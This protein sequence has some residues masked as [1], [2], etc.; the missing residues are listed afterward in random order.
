MGAQNILTLTDDNF[1]DRLTGAAY[2]VLVDFWAAWCGPCKVIA[3][4][5]EELADELSG[6]ALI[7]KID[8]EDNGGLANRFGISSIP[9]LILFKNGRVVDQMIGAV[10][11][12]QIRK[13]VEK[14]LS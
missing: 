8:V 11:K 1:D 5:L 14:H 7:G 6:Q 12:A 2:P 9:T 3:P 10:P 4:W 13:M